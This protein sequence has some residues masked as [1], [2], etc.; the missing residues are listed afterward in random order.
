MDKEIVLTSQENL[1]G[2][3]AETVAET[4]KE[5]FSKETKADNQLYSRIETANLLKV[6]LP[7]LNSWTKSGVI[8][9]YRIG[10]SVKYKSEDVNNALQKV[11]TIKYQRDRI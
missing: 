8:S 6:S 1:K 9:A 4:L 10:N 3:I 5:F 11:Q 7:T 2:L